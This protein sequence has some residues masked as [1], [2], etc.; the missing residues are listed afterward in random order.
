MIDNYYFSSLMLFLICLQLLFEFYNLINLTKEDVC[1]RISSMFRTLRNYFN[2]EIN[3]ENSKITIINNLCDTLLKR[4]PKDTDMLFTI[5][6]V[7]FIKTI[8][9][10]GIFPIV[11]YCDKY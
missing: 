2:I 7:C 5:E 6:Q 8:I 9:F 10:H 1:T 3:N 4:K 11:T